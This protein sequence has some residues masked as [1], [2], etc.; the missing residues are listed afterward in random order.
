MDDLRK[1]SSMTENST[2]QFN[3]L[4]LFYCCYIKNFKHFDEITILTC[5]TSADNSYLKEVVAYC[6]S[7]D[8][9]PLFLKIWQEWQRE[10]FDFFGSQNTEALDFFL[11]QNQFPHFFAD[12]KVCLCWTLLHELTNIAFQLPLRKNENQLIQM[13]K[14]NLN[15]P[16]SPI[17]RMSWVS[18]K[19]LE[20][21]KNND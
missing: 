3:N 6:E 5:I 10:V 1:I 12:C 21:Q 9:R 2:S 15:C 20:A 4:I 17:I 14:C 16:S 19:N 7:I 13:E 8:I 18:W 11:S